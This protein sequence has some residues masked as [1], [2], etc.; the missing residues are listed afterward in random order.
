MP[1]GEQY[2]TA[3]AVA[4]AM[5]LAAERL[6]EGWLLANRPE[7]VMQGRV[8]LR[9]RWPVIAALHCAFPWLALS[10]VAAMTGLPQPCALI[11]SD[12]GKLEL[13]PWW[14]RDL[15]DELFILVVQP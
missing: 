3:E 11:P 4:R 8:A 1:G 7:A 9:S 6:G 5:A 10:T 2:P 15:V 12:L 13:N 14:R